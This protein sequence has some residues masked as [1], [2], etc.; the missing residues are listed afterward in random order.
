MCTF[1]YVLR[2]KIKELFKRLTSEKWKKKLESFEKKY[3]FLMLVLAMSFLLY[4]IVPI[5]VKIFKNNFDDYFRKVFFLGLFVVI[6][7]LYLIISTI[8][9]E[10]M[11]FLF[12][13]LFFLGA[14]WIIVKYP[15]LKYLF[16]AIFLVFLIIYPILIKRLEP[17]WWIWS[18]IFIA[19]VLFLLGLLSIDT[20]Y[21]EKHWDFPL[22]YCEPTRTSNWTIICSNRENKIIVG[23]DL[24]CKVEPFINN[25]RGSVTFEFHDGNQNSTDYNHFLVPSNIRW[26]G[27]EVNGEDKNNQTLCL[28]LSGLTDIPTQEEYKNNKDKFITYFLALIGFIIVS[29]PSILRNIKGMIEKPR[30]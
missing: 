8:Y 24:S 6:L 13:M 28:S 26:I 27:F 23:Y 29:I 15:T 20:L 9:N 7:S 5:T 30:N 21:G 4:F 22:N 18:G 19:L 1:F 12:P 16:Y 10:G 14:F 2:T 25:S 17:N 3:R 11:Y